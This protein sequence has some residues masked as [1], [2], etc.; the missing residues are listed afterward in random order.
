MLFV[1]LYGPGTRLGSG[2]MARGKEQGFTLLEL[3]V[4][5]ALIGIM[6]SLG[7]PSFRNAFFT[8]PLK[9]S[10]RKIV[11]LIGGVRELAV[12]TRQPYFVHLSREENRLWYERDGGAGK[13]ELSEQKQLQL[14][15]G[16]AIAEIR[17]DLEETPSA[18]PVSLWITRQGYMQETRILIKDDEGKEVALQFLP[19]IDA[20][21]VSDPSVSFDE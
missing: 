6:L 13:E 15:E 19:F 4:V 8:D 1:P 14:P 10:A 20:V 7:V 16:V 11:G 21:K 9:S 5:C 2:G 12:R 18:D 17:L 3:V